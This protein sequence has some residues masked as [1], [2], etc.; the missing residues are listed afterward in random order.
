MGQNI[1]KGIGLFNMIKLAFQIN[2]KDG[3]GIVGCSF[4][5]NIVLFPAVYKK[6]QWIKVNEDE[7][8]T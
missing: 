4:K 2:G 3:W 7:I 1:A 5:R 8:K 6:S